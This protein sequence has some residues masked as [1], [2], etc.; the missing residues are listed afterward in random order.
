MNHYGS[1]VA[2]IVEDNEVANK[3]ISLA[4]N[5]LGMASESAFTMAEALEKLNLITPDF[6][7]VDLHLG[8]FGN[9]FTVIEAIR[10]KF[11]S[12]VPIL[13]ISNRSDSQAISHAL[14]LG[15]DDFIVK[16]IEK[17]ILASKLSRYLSTEE[18][19][20][21]QAQ[22]FPVPKQG[23]QAVIGLDCSVMEVDEFGLR[24]ASRHV[25][26]KSSAFHLEGK[27]LEELGGTP[28]TILFTVKSTIYDAN[29]RAFIVDV[30]FDQDDRFLASVRKWI[31][32]NAK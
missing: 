11:G 15:A 19:L 3:I 32:L 18:L 22:I 24:L 17:N 13:V 8:E 2:L 1:P 29:L 30:E 27:F 4:V 9:G 23:C 28:E 26:N 7:L 12:N 10:Q 16:P 31:N 6:F 14:E 25:F 21:S 5:K 20:L